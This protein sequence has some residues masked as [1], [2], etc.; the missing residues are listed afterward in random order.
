[1]HSLCIIP[2]TDDSGVTV[3]S[4]AY[5]AR[6]LRTSKDIR[7][8]P[9]VVLVA[10]IETRCV[11]VLRHL[12]HMLYGQGLY[13]ETC[14]TASQYACAAKAIGIHFDG[15][16]GTISGCVQ[17]QLHMGSGQST[18]LNG[19]SHPNTYYGHCCRTS[20]NISLPS[21]AATWTP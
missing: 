7:I 21:R 3:G 6:A 15:F 10:Y 19:P 2:M 18:D 5:N 8:Y 4:S 14:R 9:K 13:A 11:Q 12:R 1:M 20:I 17:M 16:C